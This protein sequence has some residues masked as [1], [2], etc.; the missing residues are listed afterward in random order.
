MSQ[1]NKETIQGNNNKMTNGKLKLCPKHL[2]QQSRLFSLRLSTPSIAG[3]IE[4]R[5]TNIE[6]RAT[7]IIELKNTTPKPASPRFH[8]THQRRKKHSIAD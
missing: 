2:E 1:I 5:Q 6:K 4:A 7:Q 8:R 3:I